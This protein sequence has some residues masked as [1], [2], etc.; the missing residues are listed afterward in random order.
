MN[1][2]K[3]ASIPLLRHLTWSLFTNNSRCDCHTPRSLQL[4]LP[5]VV[6][7]FSNKVFIS[8]LVSL[9]QYIKNLQHWRKIRSSILPRW[10]LEY[11]SSFSFMIYYR[12][13]L[14]EKF[15]CE[16]MQSGKP[17]EIRGKYEIIAALKSV[18]SW[19]SKSN[20][21]AVCVCVNVEARRLVKP[22]FYQ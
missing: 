3:F 12:R 10:V 15:V 8:L 14:V 5:I 16:V 7:K 19:V 2:V 20:V 13:K 22:R 11:A 1:T 6:P 4:Q 18:R 17:E 9:K 21:L